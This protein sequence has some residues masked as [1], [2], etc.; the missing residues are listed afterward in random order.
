[1]NII[2]SLAEKGLIKPPKWLPDNINYLTRTGSYSY[3]VSTDESDIDIVGFCIPR[4]EILFKH[5][6]GVIDGFGP[7]Q[8]VFEQYQ[9]H[10]IKDDDKS[11]DITVY[12]IVKYFQ[13]CAHNN[14]NMIDTLYTKQHCLLATTSIGNM[15][16]DNRDLFLTKN[17]YHTFKG[18]AWSQI[19]K[20]ESVKKDPLII[21]IRNFEQTHCGI[22]HSTTLEQAKVRENF[23]QLED[24]AWREYVEK[25]EQGVRQSKRFESWKTYNFDCK[26]LY[27][28]ARLMDECE[29]ILTLGTVDLTRSKEYLKAIRRGEVSEADLREKFDSKEKEL[30][31]LYDS[32]KLRYSPDWPALQTLLLNCLEEH[33]GNLKDCVATP[34]KEK[35]AIKEIQEVL[36]K[37]NL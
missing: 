17:S 29:Q 16:R 19:S 33:Y 18:Y 26:F 3:E 22:P 6:T 36:N 32:S 28:L 8:D 5:L 21:W 12:N 27:H 23:P 30:A 31:K 25:F 20:S 2:V 13:L 24:W 10:Q 14:P 7:K 37:Y 15:V 34:D 9:Q 11:Y 35:R 4:K 1:M